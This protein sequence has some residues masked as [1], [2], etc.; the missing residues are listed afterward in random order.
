MTPS[1]HILFLQAMGGEEEDSE[2]NDIVD[3]D[4]GGNF[5]DSSDNG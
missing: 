5:I 1:G 2:Y 3:D 4:E